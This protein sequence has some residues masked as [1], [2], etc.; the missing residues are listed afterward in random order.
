V[1]VR[2]DWDVVHLPRLAAVVW[3]AEKRVA[4]TPQYKGI[5]SAHEHVSSPATKRRQVSS[6]QGPCTSYR[7][8]RVTHM[9]TPMMSDAAASL[10][11]SHTGP[12]INSP[13]ITGAQPLGVLST[14]CTFRAST[15]C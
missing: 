11:N 6:T 2:T 13:L 7:D 12:R 10:I 9:L 3:R 4:A 15:Q 5:R 8:S 14:S 1:S